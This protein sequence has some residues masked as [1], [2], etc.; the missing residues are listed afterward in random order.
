MTAEKFFAHPMGII[1]AAGTAT[2]LWGS[3]FPIIKLSYE[4]LDI[5]QHEV[6]DQFLFAGYRFVLAS[7]LIFLLIKLMG[8]GTSYQS[9]T[10]KRFTKVGLF[11]TFFQ[12]LFFYLGLSYSTGIQGSII[13]GTT[14]F[15][16]ILIAHF[17]YQNDRLSMR[18]M[19]GLVVGF[20]GVI[21]VN[22]SN[23]SME[24]QFGIGEL[25]LLLSMFFGGLGNVLS[26]KEAAHMDILYLTAYQ[27]L[28]GGLCLTLAGVWNTGILPFQ[29]D[30]VSLIMLLYLAFLSAAGFGLWNNVMKYNKVGDVSMYMFLIPI[31]GVWLSAIVLEE[32][33]SLKVF[34]ALALVVAGIIIV[35]RSSERKERRLSEAKANVV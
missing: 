31:F 5:Q 23:G 3:A 21:L 13:A 16:Q 22:V 2:L 4:K 35:N 32:K 26:K 17:M 6:F 29:F 28:F 33:L 9:G 10:I 25:F 27:M 30:M 18:K 15:F 11:Q 20:S 7:L 34:A 24:F 8:K 12:Y 1:V 19:A 14:S